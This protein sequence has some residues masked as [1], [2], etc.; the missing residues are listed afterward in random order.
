M[1]Q[2]NHMDIDMDLSNYSLSDTL[3]LF[4]IP[5]QYDI[6][7]LKKAKSIVLRLHPDKSKLP[8]Q[9]FQFYLDAYTRLYTIYK[10]KTQRTTETSYSSIATKYDIELGEEEDIISNPLLSMS[11]GGNNDQFNQDL[12][13]R[14]DALKNPNLDKTGYSNWMQSKQSEIEIVDGRVSWEQAEEARSK[15]QREKRE[16]ALPHQFGGA[17]EL[18]SSGGE[19]ILGSD[20]PESYSSGIFSTIQFEDIKVAYTEKITPEY[21]NSKQYKNIEQYQSVRNGQNLAPPSQAE[22]DAFF[23]RKNQCET[24]RHTQRLFQDNLDMEAYEQR[25]NR[26]LLTN[27]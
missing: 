21:D 1:M 7:D 19:T 3:K 27:K 8:P 22:S 2:Q 17:Y 11:G 23:V 10:S 12:N 25:K 4:N 20:E 13:K 14:F 18:M 15:R 9:Y 16:I 26:F 5:M 6:D 24:N